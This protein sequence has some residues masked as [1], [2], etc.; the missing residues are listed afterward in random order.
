MVRPPQLTLEQ[1][2][3]NKLNSK[4]QFALFDDLNYGADEEGKFE[5]D[6]IYGSK[7]RGRSVSYKLKW[8]APYLHDD[9]DSWEVRKNL[10]NCNEALREY[11]LERYRSNKRRNIQKKYKEGKVLSMAERLKRMEQLC[12]HPEETAKVKTEVVRF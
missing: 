11:Q 2:E 7:G 5:V 6:Y 9:Y 8:A 3:K 4:K 12:Y 1:E 10:T